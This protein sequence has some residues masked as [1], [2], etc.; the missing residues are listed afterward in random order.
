MMSSAP[1]SAGPAFSGMLRVITV[2]SL[3]FLSVLIL[4]LFVA[5][6]LFIKKAAI[7]EMFTSPDIRAAIWLTVSTSL[8]T[9]VIA[10]IIAIPAAYALSRFAFPGRMLLDILID[11]LLV[12][13]VL[14]VGVSILVLFRFGSDLALSPLPVL[15]MVGALFTWLG[16]QIIY[17]R[18]GI[19]V[20]QFFCSVPFAVRVMKSTF[21]TI[22]PRTESVAQTLGCTATGAF[23]RVS[24]PL[25]FKGIF[26]AAILTW[27]RAFGLFGPVSLVAGAV[28]RKTEVLATSIFLEISI[29][30]IEIALAIS[31]LMIAIAFFILLAVR[32]FTR[33]DALSGG[34]LQ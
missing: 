24:L 23:M 21:D 10:L 16:D 11:L 26:A 4:S 6:I 22:D 5:D 15:R 32:L 2:S 30:R 31:I 3:V 7:A 29:G 25:A 33:T 1:Q 18:A 8:I 34:A 13:P 28:R 14:V 20:A 12:V 27:A 19:V 17:Q 9:T